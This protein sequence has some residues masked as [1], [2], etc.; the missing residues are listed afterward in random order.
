MN[1]VNKSNIYI[2]EELAYMYLP[3]QKD[4]V[5]VVFD[6]KTEITEAV[7]IFVSKISVTLLVV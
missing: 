1:Y 6:I 5:S 4:N 3:V 2:D 7:T